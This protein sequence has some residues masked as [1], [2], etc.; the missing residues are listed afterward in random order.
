MA[1]IN[2]PQ[3]KN[4]NSDAAKYL[5]LAGAIIGGAVS[6]GAGAPAGAAA[7]AAA[8]GTG[9]AAAAAPVAAGG[10]G[11]AVTGAST[12]A[13]LGGVLQGAVSSND[14]QRQPGIPQQPSQAYAMSQ[15]QQK[16]SQDNLATLQQAESQLPRL[17]EQLRQQ[18]APAVIQARMLEERQRGLV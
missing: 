12:G 14:Q 9:A 4:P 15:R 2:M 11:A 16:L 6:G 7:G 8:A 3:R 17:P 5:P 18:Y 10:I 13:G 1:Q